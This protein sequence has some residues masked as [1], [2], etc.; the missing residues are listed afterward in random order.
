MQK[1]NGIEVINTARLDEK[2]FIES[3]NVYYE[4]WLDVLRNEFNM[5]T[6][7]QIKYIVIKQFKKRAEIFPEGQLSAYH[8]S[9]NKIIGNISSLRVEADYEFR[10]WNLL[11]AQGYFVTHDP[12][13]KSLVCP[14]VNT[15]KELHKYGIKGIAKQ[16]VLAARAMAKGFKENGLEKMFVFTRPSGY[17]DY[18]TKYG[19][20]SIEKYLETKTNGQPKEFPDPIDLHLGLGAKIVRPVENARPADK[21]SLGYCVLMQYEI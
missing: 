5:L 11:T 1:I 4:A 12:K 15:S 13:G 19:S 2:H 14:A 16:L 20:A 10:D 6:D 17:R 21:A 18:T 7:K 3:A 8:A 9:L